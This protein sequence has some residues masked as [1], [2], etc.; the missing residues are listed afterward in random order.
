[1]SGVKGEL[2]SRLW[3]KDAGYYRKAAEHVLA[4]RDAGE[5]R[6]LARWLPAGLVLE[7]G[8]GDGIHFEV[9][10]RE[11]TRWVGC[12][13]SALAVGLAKER[14]Q[15]SGLVVADAEALPFAAGSFQAVLAVSV[16]EHLPEPERA[17]DA[18]I[19][20]LAPGGRLLVVSPQYGAPLG[21]SPCRNGG[22]AARFAAR[23][24]RAHLPVREGA[25]GWDRV[26]P[27]VLGGAAYS[28]DE[29]T[30]VEPE[31]R[32]LV[33]FLAAR[34]MRVLDATSG[35]TWTTWRRGRMSLG[36]RTARALFEPLG[37]TGLPPYTWWGPLVCVCAERA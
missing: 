27:A 10:A 30:V 24:V 22:G 35:L 11:G 6:W 31:L 37:R 4:S 29:D 25:L 18:M 32:T 33:A 9:L 17:L 23:F 21:A 26:D 13:L 1:M 28:G 7:V 34:G 5:Y 15:A 8:C 3:G 12:D 2:L 14:G 36:Q 16:L 19:D 20:V